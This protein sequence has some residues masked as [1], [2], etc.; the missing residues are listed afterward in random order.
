M[1]LADDGGEFCLRIGRRGGGLIGG[2]DQVAWRAQGKGEQGD[3][4]ADF[5]CGFP[6]FPQEVGGRMKNAK[7][8]AF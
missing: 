8:P 3:W 6:G 4:E 5:H 7:Q 2:T 1:D